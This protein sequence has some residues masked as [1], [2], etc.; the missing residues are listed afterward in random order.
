MRD[1]DLAFQGYS[2]I[3]H[4]K[5]KLMEIIQAERAAQRDFDRYLAYLSTKTVRSFFLWSTM[6]CGLSACQRPHEHRKQ[7]IVFRHQSIVKYQEPDAL[8]ENA[9]SRAWELY[10]DRPSCEDLGERKACVSDDNNDVYDEQGSL[11]SEE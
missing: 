10:I 1:R 6:L 3:H 8:D 7:R 4:T 2:A 5:P 11:V 9:Y